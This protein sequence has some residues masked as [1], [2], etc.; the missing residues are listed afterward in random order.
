MNK[1]Y[2]FETEIK[3]NTNK[4]TFSI[5]ELKEKIAKKYVM[6]STFND[7]HSPLLRS[8]KISSSKGLNTI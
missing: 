4:V 5:Y 3:T 6:L 1:K 8:P 2:K 7:E